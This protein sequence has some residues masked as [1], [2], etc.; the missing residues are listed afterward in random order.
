MSTQT[1]TVSDEVV[2]GSEI[3]SPSV[4]QD[5]CVHDDASANWVVRQIVER[6][7]YAR[8]CTEW[9]EQ[10]Q[11]RAQ[12]EED[13]LLFRYGPQLLEYARSR[14]TG[15]GGRRKSVNLP[16]GVVGFRSEPSEL[17]V[18]DE[19]L[20]IQWAKTYLPDAVTVVERLSKSELNEHVEQT[21][22]LPGA[23]AHIEPAREKFY[24]K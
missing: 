12:H 17:V 4:P 7:A 2:K 11:A 14:I 15:A 5:F 13:F 9:C 6:R 23:G 19:R 16:A 10:E 24:V 21:G 20:V 18:D 22:E 1:K 8:R 3:P